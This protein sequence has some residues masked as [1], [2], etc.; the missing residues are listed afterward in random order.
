MW[1]K[2]LSRKRFFF[3]SVHFMVGQVVNAQL[4]THEVTFKKHKS[5]QTAPN[6]EMKQ[7]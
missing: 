3:F 7:Y 6:I 4:R 5:I 2:N 1:S